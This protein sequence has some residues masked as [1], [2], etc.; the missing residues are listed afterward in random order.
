MKVTNKQLC[1]ENLP[2]LQSLVIIGYDRFAEVHLSEPEY[3]VGK[4]FYHREQ[5]KSNYSSLL[6]N[7][8]DW[9]SLKREIPDFWWEVVINWNVA[10][11]CLSVISTNK[12]E[13]LVV[14][15]DMEK[16]LIQ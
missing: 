2:P 12:T 9:V 16:A 8:F 3:S 15:L 6:L 4:W 1:F 11:T 10:I 5:L 13:A 14:G 7:T